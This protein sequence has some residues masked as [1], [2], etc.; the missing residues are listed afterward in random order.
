MS[1]R[2]RFN[3]ASSEFRR[4]R[5]DKVDRYLGNVARL[6]KAERGE[7]KGSKRELWS[8]FR[9]RREKGD[10]PVRADAKRSEAEE[11]ERREAEWKPR[12]RRAR[13]ARRQR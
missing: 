12:D 4:G 1:V 9:K 2:S 11:G 6:G 10:V 13:S 3:V 7:R 5:I 8:A